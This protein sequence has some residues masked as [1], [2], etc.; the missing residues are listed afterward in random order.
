MAFL[1]FL[2]KGE[3]AM[4]IVGLCSRVSRLFGRN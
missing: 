4:Y 3:V 2:L 1:Y